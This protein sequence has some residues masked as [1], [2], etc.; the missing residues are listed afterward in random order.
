M[1]RTFRLKLT[2][3]FLALSL[4]VYVLTATCAV[5][6]F[7][8]VLTKSLDDRLYMLASEV[9]H[10][11]DLVGQENGQKPKLREWHRRVTTDPARGLASAQ[12]F[13]RNGVMVEAFGPDGISHFFKRSGEVSEKGRH[14]RVIFTPLKLQSAIVGFV[15]VN[16]A[17]EDRDNS[18]QS[19]I[20]TL[21]LAGPFVLIGLG[22]TSYFV[23][24]LAAEPLLRNVQLM[25]RFV[26]DA[27][28]ELNSPL[29]IVRAKTE[30][31]ENRLAKQGIDTEEIT[32]SVRS[33]NRMEKIISDLMYLT[34]LDAESVTEGF[35]AIDVGQLLRHVSED[36]R[37]RFEEK[38]IAFKVCQDFQGEIT[39]DAELLYR[40]FSNLVENAL[41]YTDKGE[42][43]IAANHD[44]SEIKITIK[45]SGIGIEAD[46]LTRLFERFYR[47][48]KSRSRTSGGVG[49]GLSI[50]KTIVEKHRGAITIVSRQLQGTEVTLAFPLL[51]RP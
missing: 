29:S 31:L 20:V 33:L 9:G 3:Y 12:L 26:E 7:S 46:H 32:A 25:R 47:V 8:G 35:T 4:I 24:G 36:F 45:D 5:M 34:E 13:D 37:D 39:G 48:D 18:V 21:C 2:L 22:L 11:I 19:L 16:T 28:H 41:R 49:L 42:V 1:I 40:A 10:A 30:S 43:E 44:R 14:Y 17:T 27:G 6:F 38:N 50:V 23:S 15:Q 51:Q